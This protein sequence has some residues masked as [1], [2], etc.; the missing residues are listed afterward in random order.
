MLMVRVASSTKP[1]NMGMVLEVLGFWVLGFGVLVLVW[2]FGVLGFWGFGFWVG[3][4]SHAHA[5]VD[6]VAHDVV[7]D[8]RQH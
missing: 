1:P 3:S 7:G 2:G 8:G 6:V 5:L 4:C